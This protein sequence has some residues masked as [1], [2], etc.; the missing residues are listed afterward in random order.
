[1]TEAEV[2]DVM[3]LALKIEEALRQ[4]IQVASGSSESQGNGFF[5]RA[6]RRDAALPTNFKRLLS[7]IR[8]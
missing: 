3:L 2:G 8:L 6:S 1:M 5:P 4:G 7:N